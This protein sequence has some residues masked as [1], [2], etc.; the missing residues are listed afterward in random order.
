MNRI[1]AVIPVR[2]GS[3]R[4]KNKNIRNFEDTSLLKLKIETLK[5]VKGIDIILVSSNCDVMLGIALDMGV[6]IYRRDDK[7]CTNENPG[8]FFCNLADSVKTDFMMHTPVTSPFISSDM[9]N[10]MIEIWKSVKENHDSFNSTSSIKEFI[11]FDNKSINYDKTNPPPSQDL[12]DYRYLNFGCNI[13]SVENVKKY[14]NIIGNNPYLYNINCVSGMD[15]D[16]SYEFIISELIYKNNFHNSNKCKQILD[17]RTDKISLIDCTIRDGGYLNN[18]EFSYEEVLDCYKSVTDAG[19]EY[20]EIGFRTNRNLL[21]NK[22]KWCYCDEDDIN[23]ISDAY[24][25]CEIAVMAKLGTVTIEDFL[26]SKM[27]KI[28]LV[29]ILIARVTKLGDKNLSKYN[30][31][32]L[33]NAKQFAIDLLDLGY[34]VCINLGCG[35][36]IDDEE[37]EIIC[38]T[39]YELPILC[40]YLADTYGGFNSKNI[41]IQFHKF[42]DTLE[43]LDSKIELGFH[44]HNNNGDGLEKAKTAIFHGCNFIDVSINGLGRGAGNLKYE[45]YLCYKYEDDALK[46]KI[47]PII[48]F[49]NKNLISKK[50]YVNL[51]IQQHPYYN[52][53][54][55][56][57]LHPDYINEILNNI[58]T[59]VEH[60]LDLIYELDRFTKENNARNYDKNLIG[61][62]SNHTK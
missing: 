51:K 54:G 43:N 4:C 8:S 37:L 12:P 34:K 62:L 55:K 26:P 45:E 42:Y 36:L 11:W 32:D 16:E 2:K 52:I 47:R 10:K 23:K 13:I 5:K 57:S 40:L 6:D 1:T 24:D 46:E 44:I 19:C 59:S 21:Q 17:K 7:F 30:L 9:Y 27:S 50:D 48:N 53:A 18:W 35:D 3:T 31:N 28:K 39:F 15:I 60:D 56:L 61:E 41:P 14:N 33:N 49:F 20:F 58:N 29:R 22:G 25:G 38:N